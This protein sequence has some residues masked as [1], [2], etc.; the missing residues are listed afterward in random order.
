MFRLCSLKS[1]NSKKVKMLYLIGLGL[2]VKDTSLKGLE[3]IKRCEKVYLEAYTN[4][5]PYPLMKLER[6]IGKKVVRADREFVEQNSQLLEEAKKHDV[7]LL[8]YGSPL[9][10]T[11]HFELLLRAAKMKVK[12]EV[13]HASSVFTAVSSCGLQLYKF[14][15]V[16]SIP[17]W[18]KSYAPESFFD[19]F[20]ENRKINAH[21]LLLIDIGLS[22]K[23]A[24]AQLSQVAIKR[25]EKLDKIIVCSCLG[26]SRQKIFYDSLDRLK[27]RLKASKI[28]TPACII[29]PASLHFLEAEALE[30][31]AI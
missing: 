9:A 14:G 10:A 27:D 2:D 15:K 8:V 31:F 24:L 18:Q 16:A 23:D 5:F 17:R 6:V 4:E 11:T 3:V 7:C 30:N 22:V 21:T 26:T 25:G 13:I 1:K 19:V 20:L 28:A 12:A 29:I